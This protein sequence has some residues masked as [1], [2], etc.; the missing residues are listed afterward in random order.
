MS[1]NKNNKKEQATKLVENI[2][3][4]IEEYAKINKNITIDILD[5]VYFLDPE[6][7]QR[8]IWLEK[9]SNIKYLKGVILKY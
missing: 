2:I 6:R 3:N 4:S 9:D 8:T 7:I 1:K 5:V